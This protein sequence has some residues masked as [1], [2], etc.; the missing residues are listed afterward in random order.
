MARTIAE[1][2]FTLHVWAFRP[3]SLNALAGVPHVAHGSLAELAGASRAVGLCLRLDSDIDEV[4]YDA[5]LLEGLEPEAVLVN[6]G[7]GLPGFAVELS[8]HAASRGV[9]VLDAPV[10]G[11]RPGA[12]ARALTTIVGRDRA[13]LGRMRTVS[14]RSPGRSPTWDRPALGNLASCSTTPC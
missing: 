10:S 3:Q 12:E 6:H 2:G 7:T 14:S 4:L 8:H 5:G 9:L 11:G 13:V 1:G